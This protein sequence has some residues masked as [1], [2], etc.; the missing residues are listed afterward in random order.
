ME[1]IT[2]CMISQGQ[3]MM[4]NNHSTIRTMWN[5]REHDDWEDGVDIPLQYPKTYDDETFS[6][7]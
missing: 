5:D 3:W 2:I 1:S 4:M 6:D 7:E